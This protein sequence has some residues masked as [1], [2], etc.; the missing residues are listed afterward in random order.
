M[1]ITIEGLPHVS[2]SEPIDK[3]RNSCAM[4]MEI[5]RNETAFPF[6]S[7]ECG[8]GR[9]KSVPESYKARRMCVCVCV[10]VCVWVCGCV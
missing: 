2:I 9:V 8:Q 6:V 4:N 5:L 3:A 7:L 10:C 1:N